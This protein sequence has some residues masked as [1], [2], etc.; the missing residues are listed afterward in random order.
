M[1]Y[2]AKSLTRQLHW[3]I[4]TILEMVYPYRKG[5]REDYTASLCLTFILLSKLVHLHFHYSYED[6]TLQDPLYAPTFFA[7]DALVFLVLRAFLD[8]SARLRRVPARKGRSVGTTRCVLANTMFLAGASCS[9]FICFLTT[10]EFSVY[11]NIGGLCAWPTVLEVFS[12]PSYLLIFWEQWMTVKQTWFVCLVPVANAALTLCVNALLH[13][14]SSAFQRFSTRPNSNAIRLGTF[15]MAS[16]LFKDHRRPWVS[17]ALLGFTLTGWTIFISRTYHHINKIAQ[18]STLQQK[19]SSPTVRS[20]INSKL[21]SPPGW[22]IPLGLVTC[23][24]PSRPPLFGDVSVTVPTSVIH[25]LIGQTSDRCP[26]GKPWPEVDRNHQ[27]QWIRSLSAE[28]PLTF[29]SVNMSHYWPKDFT[30][31]DGFEMFSHELLAQ[32]ADDHEAGI[33]RRESLSG[34]SALFDDTKISNLGSAV[35]PSLAHDLSNV[36]VRNVVLILMESTPSHLFPF[37]PKSPFYTR[38][39]TARQSHQSYD[40]IRNMTPI[41]NKLFD[42]H[43]GRH[44][45]AKGGMSVIG[46]ESTCSYTLKS[47]MA[48]HC[49]VYPLPMD[50][51]REAVA[52]AHLYQP[53]LPH[54]LH[55]LNDMRG[56][57]LGSSDT[58]RGKWRLMF[59]QPCDE[60]WDRQMDIMQ[61]VGFDLSEEVIVKSTLAHKDAPYPV[62]GTNRRAIKG[63]VFLPE[64]ALTPYFRDF[65]RNVK[66]RG[67]RFFLSHLTCST[68]FPWPLPLGWDMRRYTD[69]EELNSLLNAMANQDE[70]IGKLLQVLEEEGV[71][72][73]T[74][75][76]MTGD[77]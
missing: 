69:D 2:H 5:T 71:M 31:P 20:T 61:Q 23:L 48:S 29:P 26:V 54:I 65:V 43:G 32:W 60:R 76:V 19:L 38:A 39:E 58:G 56:G 11:V 51:M 66:Q 24:I 21:L 30:P 22:A 36:R 64:D 62:S 40:D 18:G 37:G 55:T 15:A 63:E 33:V 27:M 4:Y 35:H 6:F 72:N 50:F 13:A 28:D 77:Q 45:H 3:I 49:G 14:A 47:L 75:V 44:E 59:G 57:S 46:A 12:T 53:C 34:Y 67:D 74:L 1:G 7:Y 10:V 9:L 25:S 17:L 73:E 68:H 42:T 8:C 52:D 70:W 41:A 16:L